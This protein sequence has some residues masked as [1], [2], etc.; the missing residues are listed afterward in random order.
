MDAEDRS[1]SALPSQTFSRSRHRSIRSCRVPVSDA[2]GGR[3]VAA[4]TRSEASIPDRLPEVQG[5][6]SL[7][8]HAG[9]E[10]TA[11]APLRRRNLKQG[12]RTSDRGSNPFPRIA[13]AHAGGCGR[14]LS[15]RSSLAKPSPAA[16]IDPAA[17]VE[18]PRATRAGAG[19]SQPG[20]AAKRASR[21][22]FP[23]S[24]GSNPFPRMLG[25]S[26]RRAPR[27]DEGI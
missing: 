21:T 9:R 7:P 16:V 19:K 26:E 10:R 5:F 17:P 18:S 2:S 11:S 24:K 13:P 8:S 6:K 14:P 12:G 1:R 27:C 3:E 25:A 23:R 22:V 15:E 20:R 4:R